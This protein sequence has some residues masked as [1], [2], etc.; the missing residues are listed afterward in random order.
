MTTHNLAHHL[1]PL[2]SDRTNGDVALQDAGPI[3][4]ARE[5]ATLVAVEDTRR[6]APA[7][8]DQIARDIAEIEHASAVLRQAEPALD[9]WN[10][11]PP[12]T[13]G[14]P[15]PVWLLIGALWISTALVTLGAVVA[16]AVLVG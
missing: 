12:P 3:A 2:S 4:A 16:I 5:A 6:L 9:T 15:R 8:R 14:K 10:N 7:E 1:G 13:L 11:A